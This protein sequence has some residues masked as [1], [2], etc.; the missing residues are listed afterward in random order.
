MNKIDDIKNKIIQGNTL[1]VLKT[2]PDE[3]VDCVVT[4]PPY[5]GLRDYGEETC[6]IWDEDPNCE[7]EWKCEYIRKR[8]EGDKPCPASG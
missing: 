6:T 5:F 7:H 4:S 1:D 3:S 2:F 8:T